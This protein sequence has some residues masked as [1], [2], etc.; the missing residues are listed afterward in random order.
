VP[1]FKFEIKELV[2]EHTIIH[3]LK[4]DKLDKH[5]EEVIIPELGIYGM[6]Q[7]KLAENLKT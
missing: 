5:T 2:K 4:L 1:N 3:N 7:I 6:K